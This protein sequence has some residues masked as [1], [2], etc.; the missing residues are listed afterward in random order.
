MTSNWS[1]ASQAPDD[2]SHPY[3]SNA[4][5]TFTAGPASATQSSSRGSSGMRSSRATPPIGSN[6]ISR[7][8]MP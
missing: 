8:L 5:T 6:V 3:R 1:T 2:R 7:V 4:I